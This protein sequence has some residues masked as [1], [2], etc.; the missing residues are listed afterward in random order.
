MP[1]PGTPV[2]SIPAIDPR[3]STRRRVLLAALAGGALAASGCGFRLRGPQQLAFATIHVGVSELSDFGAALRRLIATSGTTK[4]I[5]DAAQADARLNI[6]ANERGREILSLTG[7]GK[8]REYQIS[9]R[10]RFQLLDKAGNTLIPPTTLTANREYT[11]DDSQILG[12]EQEEA[13]LYRDMQHD[14]LLQL[15]RRLAAVRPPA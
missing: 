15:M 6:L 1:T 13:L 8:V 12:K 3:A 14:L 9:Q 10:L 2:H 4:V 5:D 7:S 11:F